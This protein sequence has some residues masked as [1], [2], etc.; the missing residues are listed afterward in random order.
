MFFNLNYFL[1]FF[2]KEKTTNEI[3]KAS[4]SLRANDAQNISK[5][6]AEEI[7]GEG[8]PFPFPKIYQY[9]AHRSKKKSILILPTK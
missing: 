1:C 3:V 2:F 5:N 8:K 7:I 6:G 9:K 4:K